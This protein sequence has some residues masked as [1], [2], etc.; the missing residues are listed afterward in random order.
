MKSAVT[1]NDVAKEAGVTRSMV[2]YVIS[3]NSDRSVAPETRRR[4]L[5]AIEKLGYRPNKAAQALQQGDVAFAANKIGVVLCASETFLR[6]YYA[7]IISGIHLEAHE[8]NCQV[9]FIRFFNELKNPVLFNSLIHEEEIGG[10]ILV[11]TDQC[12]K[13]D[14]DKKIIEKIKGRLSKIVCI[15]FQYD[16]L[17]SV[18]FD[19]QETA[20][21][22]AEYLIQK[23]FTDIGYIGE[24]DDR[25]HGVQLALSEKNLNAKR[26]SF[27]IAETFDMSGGFKAVDSFLSEKEI[28]RAIVCGSDEVAIGVLRG[29]DKRNISV[30][31]EVA[32]ISIDNIEISE[33]TCPPLTTMNVQKKAMGEQ[34]VK[35]II[36]G[37]AGKDENA[38]K[39]VLPSSLVV[40]A[41][42]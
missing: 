27:F 38:L 6:P 2:S 40:R 17:S 22:A 19:R 1:Q 36:S 15:E 23:G 34:A 32:V 9:S 41:S 12:L 33:Y 21:R 30:P 28:P 14:E 3:G 18:M 16:G 13:T 11:A 20:R 39:V 42:C 5:N 25:V 8:Q 24:N 37:T 7:E 26:D 10:L 35:M 4:I 29:L 31:D